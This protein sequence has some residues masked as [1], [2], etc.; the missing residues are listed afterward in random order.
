MGQCYC[1]SKYT[2]KIVNNIDLSGNKSLYFKFGK[3]NRHHD[4]KELKTTFVLSDDI[5]INEVEL[6][7]KNK[8]HPYFILEKCNADEYSLM[9]AKSLSM[10]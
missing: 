10:S 2:I 5:N 7:I 8:I 1:G 9:L 3:S 6:M 4:I